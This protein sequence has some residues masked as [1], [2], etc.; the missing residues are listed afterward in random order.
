MSELAAARLRTSGSG[1]LPADEAARLP[2]RLL[3]AATSMFL[4]HGYARASMEAI[5]RAAGASTKTIYSRYRN[6][7]EILAATIRR[8]V[9]RTLPPLLEELEDDADATEPRILLAAIASRLV[10]LVT[11]E[12]K[13]WEMTALTCKLGGYQGA[14]RGPAGQ[15]MVFI[16]FGEVQLQKQK[17]RGNPR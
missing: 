7:D 13:A 6:K 3:D 9:D 4:V 8:L 10:K 5:A 12:D 14:Y 2:D 17:Q 15:T 1:R 16:T 11:T